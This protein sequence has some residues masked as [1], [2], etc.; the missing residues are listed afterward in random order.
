MSQDQPENWGDSSDA[1]G[2]FQAQIYATPSSCSDDGGWGCA[3]D[4][5][6]GTLNILSLS[7]PSSEGQL[8]HDDG[9]GHG[10]PVQ[11]IPDSRVDAEPSHSNAL[12]LECSDTGHRSEAQHSVQATPSSSLSTDG[13]DSQR[14]STYVD[15]P[16]E[17]ERRPPTPPDIEIQTPNRASEDELFV[18]MVQ[19]FKVPQIVDGLTLV[20][21]FCPGCATSMEHSIP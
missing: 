9:P 16:N 2:Q 17:L 21:R 20:E 14:N 13:Q 15:S 10:A 1:L 6:L 18:G 11:F 3:D 8:E 7:S 19:A 5:A 4:D 12:I